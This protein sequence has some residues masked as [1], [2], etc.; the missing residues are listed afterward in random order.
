MILALDR[1]VS[2]ILHSD[3]RIFET[4][5]FC[6]PEI[7]ETPAREIAGNGRNLIFSEIYET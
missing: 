3:V 1:Q 4:D 6:N 2:A 7:T 5:R